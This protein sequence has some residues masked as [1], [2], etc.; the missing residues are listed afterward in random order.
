MGELLVKLRKPNSGKITINQIAIE[1]IDE[2][3][4]R[5]NVINVSQESSLRSGTLI[6]NIVYGLED[7]NPVDIDK[8][9]QISELYDWVKELPDGLNTK[10]GEQAMKISGGE[11]QRI[12]I[13]RAVLRNPAILILDEST[14]AL[15]NI[16]EQKIYRNIR[17]NLK[18]T[19]IIIITHRLAITTDMDHLLLL[20][21]GRIAEY[22]TSEEL[23]NRRGHYSQIMEQYGNKTGSISFH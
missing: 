6:D 11:R 23:L 14:S 18:N 22:G 15:D 20:K 3:W 9:L 19:S 13:A 5:K 10:V 2:K 16:T 8:A 7:V 1:D 12:C 21:N 17:K 4:F